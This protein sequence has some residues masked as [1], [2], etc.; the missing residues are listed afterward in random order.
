M[1]VVVQEM[2]LERCLAFRQTPAPAVRDGW[3]VYSPLKEYERL[4][5]M[6]CEHWRLSQFNVG[7]QAVKTYPELLGV[8]ACVSDEELQK[9]ASFRSLFRIPAVCWRHM[10]GGVLFRAG[11]PMIGVF[12]SHCRYHVLAVC[13]HA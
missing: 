13:F 11:Q 8:P 9:S 12:G 6:N 1:R 3:L 2:A 7:Y 10:N 5:I 4:G